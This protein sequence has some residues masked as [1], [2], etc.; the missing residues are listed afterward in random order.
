[1]REQERDGGRAREA[2]LRAGI[3]L[4]K[5][6]PDVRYRAFVKGHIV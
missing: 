2:A 5:D 6:Q 1:M 4:S 3:Q